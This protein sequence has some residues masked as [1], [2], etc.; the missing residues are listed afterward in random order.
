LTNRTGDR[1]RTPYVEIGDPPTASRPITWVRVAGRPHAGDVSQARVF[2][3]VLE[4]ELMELQIQLTKTEARVA[5]AT[6]STD[7]HVSA[8][9]AQIGEI[10]KL[11]AG[12]GAR[13]M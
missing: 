1:F 4:A 13:F 12:L 11:L 10:Q 6:Q 3:A 7:A 5:P 2:I 9:R 8:L